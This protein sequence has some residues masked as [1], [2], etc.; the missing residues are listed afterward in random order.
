METSLVYQFNAKAYDILELTYFR[1]KASSPRNAVISMLGNGS[2]NILDMCTG[3]GT[4]AI[5]IAKA[6]RNAKVIGIDISKEM[7]TMAKQKLEKD[8]TPNIEVYEMDAANMQF[9]KDKFDIVLISLVLHELSD[10]L[11]GKMI[12][13][14]KR[15]LKPDGKLIVVEWEEPDS[16]LAKLA[17]Y[18]IKK[19][20]HQ[21]FEDFLKLNMY[22]YFEKHSFQIAKIVHCDYSKVITLLKKAKN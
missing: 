20:E 15:V 4:N 18:A 17:F 14:A 12:A 5:A 19:M 21:G 8:S 1:K 16:R 10:E 2:L 9:S 11:A 3:T 7:L 22:D 6:N 13:E